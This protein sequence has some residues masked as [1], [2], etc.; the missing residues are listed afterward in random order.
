MDP[1]AQTTK[2][3]DPDGLVN[4]A[5]DMVRFPSHIPDEGPLGEFLANEMRKLGCY[6]EVHLQPVVPGRYNVIGI[7]RGS[8][9]GQNLLLNGHLDI[10]ANFGRW[11]RAPYEPSIEGGWL[12]GSGVTD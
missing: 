4:L 3:V 9:G 10:P 1:I 5:S 11:Q 12:Y 6:D 8:G 2:N 7:I